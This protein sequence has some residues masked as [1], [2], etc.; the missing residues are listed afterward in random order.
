MTDYLFGFAVGDRV[1]RTDFEQDS[2]LMMPVGSLGTVVRILVPYS[3]VI[4][5]WDDENS[6]VSYSQDTIKRL[7]HVIVEDKCSEV[8]QIEQ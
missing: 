6:I 8:L 2:R 7:A 4:V 1:V 5:R 3:E